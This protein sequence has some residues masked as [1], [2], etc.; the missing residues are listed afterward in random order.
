MEYPRYF[1]LEE[2]LTSA[3]ARQKSIENIPSFEIVENITR[4]ALFLDGIR[5]AWGGGISISSG[6]R[7]KSLNKAVGGVKNSVHQ[8]GNAADIIPT[9]GKFKEFVAFLKD[10]LKDKA[11]DQCIIEKNNKTQWVHFGLY[12]PTGE[13]RRM[14][15]N[16][17]V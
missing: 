9:N 16:L 6:Y 12:S 4:L 17:E 5:E 7:N 14:S 13:Q 15:F 2:F 8:T 10:Y 3:T 1:T 11:Y